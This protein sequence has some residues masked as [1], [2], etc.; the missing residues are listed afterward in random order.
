[1]RSVYLKIED[2]FYATRYSK[3]K[4]KKT[5]GHSMTPCVN[6]SRNYIYETR[7][8]KNDCHPQGT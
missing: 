8:I 1:M 5:A 2:V 4:G 7:S 6:N 3:V